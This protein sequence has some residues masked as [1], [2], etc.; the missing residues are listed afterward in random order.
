M[1]NSAS[2]GIDPFIGRKTPRLSERLLTGKFVSARQPAELKTA[3]RRHLDDR[4]TTREFRQLGGS[5]RAI[6]EEMSGARMAES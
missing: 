5:A 1:A 2:A 3:L 6:P 4:G